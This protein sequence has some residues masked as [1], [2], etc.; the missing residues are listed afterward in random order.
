MPSF[1]A[2]T[3]PRSGGPFTGP[4]ALFHGLAGPFTGECCTAGR[5][6]P[7]VGVPRFSTP[8]GGAPLPFRPNQAKL[9]PVRLARRSLARPSARS[10]RSPSRSIPP[11]RPAERPRRCPRQRLHRRRRGA[12]PAGGGGHD[13]ARGREAG[14]EGV[15]PHRLLRHPAG[16]VQRRDHLDAA[17]LPPQPGPG[18]D[19]DAAPAAQH[20]PHGRRDEREPHLPRRQDDRR[21]RLRVDLRGRADRRGHPHQEHARRAG[22]ARPARALPPH[23]RPAPHGRRSARA[24]P[25]ARRTRSSARRRRTISRRTASSSRRRPS[26]RWPRRTGRRWRARRRRS[27]SAAWA[28]PP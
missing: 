26:P 17:Q 23:R 21:L 24:R 18:P 14:D 16:E 15:R 4:L 2:G 1:T 20:H 12:R 19:Q 27:S 7:R 10:R 8:P 22:A 9:A 11:G 6:S 3:L 28:T 25:G 5:S 13:A